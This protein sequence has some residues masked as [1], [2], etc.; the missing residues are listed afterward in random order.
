MPLE[1]E[2]VGSA[3]VRAHQLG[4]SVWYD[5][6][7]S[8]DEFKHL[9]DRVGIRGATTN[10][11]IF[12]KALLSVKYQAAI[13]RRVKRGLTAEEVYQE[14]TIEAV[15]GAADVFNGLYEESGHLD[16]FV[17]IEV[18]P[19]LAHDLK[20]TV[21]QAKNLFALIDRPNVMIKVP[22]TL[23]GV[24]ATEQLVFAGIPVNATLIFSVERYRAVAGAY[25]KALE[26]RI[27]AQLPVDG[28]RSVASFFVSR[29]DAE[30]DG[31]LEGR[32]AASH[33]MA[34]Q[35]ALGQLR[36]RAA[37][38]NAKVAYG[39]F[40]RLFLGESFEALR[41]RQAEPQRLLWAST[42]T[43]NP[44]Y[45]D[46]LYVEELMGPYT[47]NTMPPSTLEAFV[48]HGIC[49]L[50]I[51]RD[52]AQARQVLEKL[53]HDGVNVDAITVSLEEAGLRQFCD[54][55]SKIIQRIGDCK[56]EC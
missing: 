30:V 52:L 35:R 43:K 47:V 16:G 7:V 8:P 38:A 18:S 34:H 9:I 15:R 54:A 46:V 2:S 12:E 1:L 10:P 24:E 55:Y 4:Q 14:L 37:I 21:S 56:N 17:S 22:A 23:A 25:V 19:L 32:I 44:L 3:V 36:G 28:I 33:S 51:R 49:E 42:G 5:G 41:S 27:D 40:E 31:A 26:R 45:R 20:L 11:A 53:A 13:R 29:L 50:K 6:L 39:E 48:D